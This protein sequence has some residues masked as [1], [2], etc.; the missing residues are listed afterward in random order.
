[1]L[2]TSKPRIFTLEQADGFL[3]PKHT[4]VFNRVIRQYTS[5]GFS[6]TWQIVPLE[7]WG[8]PQYRRRLIIIASW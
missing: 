8:L 1:M 3:N 4:E 5:L 6:V 7:L 2:L